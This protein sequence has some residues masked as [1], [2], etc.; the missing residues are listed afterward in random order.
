[1]QGRKKYRAAEGYMLLVPRLPMRYRVA[2]IFAGVGG[3]PIVAFTN[4]AHSDYEILLQRV[5]AHIKVKLEVN[6]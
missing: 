6:V 1:M 3:Q 4:R 5:Q 2:G